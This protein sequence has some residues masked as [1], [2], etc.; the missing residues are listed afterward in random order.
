MNAHRFYRSEQLCVTE[1]HLRAVARYSR[2]EFRTE[3]EALKLS[4]NI[5]HSWKLRLPHSRVSRATVTEYV[6]V[7]QVVRACIFSI[8]MSKVLQ[9]ERAAGFSDHH[10]KRLLEYTSV[11]QV[12]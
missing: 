10:E 5:S 4:P 11:Q 8:Q 1:S 3:L 9:L 6:H 2:S 7:G 12:L